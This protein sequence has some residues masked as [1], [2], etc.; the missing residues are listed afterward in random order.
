MALLNH[1]SMTT[2]SFFDLISA[3]ESAWRVLCRHEAL[4]SS[5]ASKNAGQHHEHDDLEQHLNDHRAH[6]MV[7]TLAPSM[8]RARHQTPSDAIRGALDTISER[9]AIRKGMTTP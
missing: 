8:A 1:F 7:P 3:I 5:I 9:N 4:F 6:Q 2:A